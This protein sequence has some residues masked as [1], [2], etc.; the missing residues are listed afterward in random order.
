MNLEAPK[1]APPEDEIPSSLVNPLANTPLSMVRSLSSKG[2]GRTFVCS[3]D[4][5]SSVPPHA[6][7]L[8]ASLRV[9]GEI[10]PSDLEDDVAEA[11]ERD[12]GGPEHDEDECQPAL[13]CVEE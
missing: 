7:D 8:V 11:A 2:M 6:L 12:D 1:T 10:S 3:D 4:W 9:P 13:V 5:V